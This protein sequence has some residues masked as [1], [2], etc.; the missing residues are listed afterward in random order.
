MRL[1]RWIGAD[2]VDFMCLLSTFTPQSVRGAVRQVCDELRFMF[3]KVLLA[4]GRR[5]RQRTPVRRL[6]KLSQ[7]REVE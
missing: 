4:V 7:I 3:Q 6:S 2:Q 5:M 1:E